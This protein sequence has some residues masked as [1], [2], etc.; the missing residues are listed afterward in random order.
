MKYRYRRNNLQTILLGMKRSK[1][2][3]GENVRTYINNFVVPKKDCNIYI[4]FDVPIKGCNI[5]I[6]FVVPKKTVISKDIRAER[7]SNPLKKPDWKKGY[8]HV[9]ISTK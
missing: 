5:Y 7:K 2:I 4:F 1:G 3:L 8:Q 9:F 6:F